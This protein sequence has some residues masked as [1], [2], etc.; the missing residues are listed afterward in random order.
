MT[1]RLRFVIAV[2]WLHIALAAAAVVLAMVA[3]LLGALLT[4]LAFVVLGS[5]LVLW[6]D[7]WLE[8][9]GLK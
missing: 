7:A 5:S 6:T 1:A 9:L 8:R 2:V 4:S 3:M